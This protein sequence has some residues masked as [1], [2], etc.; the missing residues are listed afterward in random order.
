MLGDVIVFLFIAA[1]V[2]GS[3]SKIISDKK[4]GIKCSGC[5]LSKVCASNRTGPNTCSFVAIPYAQ[6]VK[7]NGRHDPEK[8]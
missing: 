3:I 7:Q 2:A 4:K 6:A 1:I 5:P 8:Q